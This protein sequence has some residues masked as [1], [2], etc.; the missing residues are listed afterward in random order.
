MYKYLVIAS[1]IT[2]AGGTQPLTYEPDTFIG[3]SGTEVYF[4]EAYSDIVISYQPGKSEPVVKPSKTAP[5]EI[6]STDAKRFNSFEGLAKMLK[7]NPF[8]QL[9]IGSHTDAAEKPS[10][11]E[12]L[13]TKRARRI[14]AILVSLG[15]DSLQLKAVGYGGTIPDK[16]HTKTPTDQFFRRTELRITGR[17]DHPYFAYTDT[18]FF[19][20]Q[21]KLIDFTFSYDKVELLND[22]SNLSHIAAIAEMMK[23]N[24][25]IKII[26]AVFTDQRGNGRYNIR[27]ASLRAKMVAGELISKGIS[28]DRITV[29]GGGE[30]NPLFTLQEINALPE[31][32]QQELRYQQNRRT[33]IIINLPVTLAK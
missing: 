13:S 15:V 4:A 22:S 23:K 12:A 17:K 2:F 31:K 33:E 32:Q 10:I 5:V 20:L 8:L 1:I 6:V 27:L 3:S 24:T 16:W 28:A 11:N 14:K 19:G 25:N 18:V 21:R 26:V 7:A 29:F 30:W 9:E